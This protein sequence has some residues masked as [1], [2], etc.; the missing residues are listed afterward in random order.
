[1]IFVAS[2]WGKSRLVGECKESLWTFGSDRIRLHWAQGQSGILGNET[3]DAV[4]R[5]G[6]LSGGDLVVV[7]DPLRG[8][9]G[10]GGTDRVVV[11]SDGS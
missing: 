7:S 2:V 9:R 1:M 8:S 3:A 11:F 6:S 4:A 10:V 5:L